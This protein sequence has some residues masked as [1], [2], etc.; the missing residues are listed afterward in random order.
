MNISFR[1]GRMGQVHRTV[2]DNLHGHRC[3]ILSDVFEGCV[4]GAAEQT[5]S[6]AS[7]IVSCFGELPLLLL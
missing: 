5:A 6:M 7:K 4:G 1:P 2:F 3:A